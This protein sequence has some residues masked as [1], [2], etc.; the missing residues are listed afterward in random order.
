MKPES[1]VPIKVFYKK[2]VV[3]EIAD[4]LVE[5]NVIVEHKTVSSLTKQMKH[6]S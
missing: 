5:E 4:I 6:N 1:E 2:E 3:G